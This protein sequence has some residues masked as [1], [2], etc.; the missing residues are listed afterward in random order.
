VAASRFQ[1]HD[2][3]NAVL[4]EDFHEALG[5]VALR[6]DEAEAAPGACKLIR[7]VRQVRT[8]PVSGDAEHALVAAQV[9]FLD[10]RVPSSPCPCSDPERAV[11]ILGYLVELLTHPGTSVDVLSVTWWDFVA[12]QVGAFC[13]RL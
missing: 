12:V 10:A 9:V 4:R 1:P 7:R 3:V 2:V 11:G 6:V 5:V 8:L 13:V